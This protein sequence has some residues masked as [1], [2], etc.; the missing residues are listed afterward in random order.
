MTT[1]E[2]I[3]DTLRRSQ[4]RLVTAVPGHGATQT[5]AAWQRANDASP[6][7]SYHEEVAVGM[8]HGASLLGHRAVVLL[9]A[10]GFLKAGNAI[11]DSLAAGTTAGLLFVVFHDP[12]GAHSD[13]VLE[14]EGAAREL[15]L[16]VRRSEAADGVQAVP[17]A[18][19]AAEGQGLPQVVIVDA[20]AVS[21]TVSAPPD[22][23]DPPAV[24]YERDAARHVCCPLFAQY[25]HA[26]F[27]ARREGTNPDAVA[28]PDLPTVPDGL[29]DTYRSLAE[30]YQPLLQALADRPRAVAAGD[31]TV[32]TLFALPPVEAVDLCTYMGGSIPLALGGQAVGETPAWAV[33][34]DFGFVA[35]GHLG[36]LEAQ[37]RS[38]PLNVVL[39]ENRRAHATG[40]QPV[41]K[42]AIDTVL[43][44]YTDHV[45]P[46]D[47]PTRPAA[48]R[49]ALATAAGRDGL[50]IVRAGYTASTEA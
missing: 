3:A 38:L 27:R 49:E 24:E 22:P 25:Q 7:F 20:D 23:L 44:G 41:S 31:T 48:C 1:A 21:E 32:G 37:Q 10:H 18:L 42:Q 4:V 6:S 17:Q 5:Y 50:A 33:T 39:L 16:S 8:A 36:L 2:A 9:K 45:V 12:T 47:T 26:V 13:S 40:G 34:G 46:L 28:C 43:A 19:R 15:G 35:A 30:R 14:I 11:A 29:P